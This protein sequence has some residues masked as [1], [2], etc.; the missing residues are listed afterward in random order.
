MMD[1]KLR[2]QADALDETF[3][4]NMYVKEWDEHTHEPTHERIRLWLNNDITLDRVKNLWKLFSIISANEEWDPTKQPKG[5]WAVTGRGPSNLDGRGGPVHWSAAEYAA[6]K[7]D[8]W[9]R[10]MHAI[11]ALFPYLKANMPNDELEAFLLQFPMYYRFPKRQIHANFHPMDG[12]D[13]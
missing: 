2:M 5:S 13:L 12:L 9:T 8:P 3:K 7:I 6:R 11:G 10:D 4:R 1:F